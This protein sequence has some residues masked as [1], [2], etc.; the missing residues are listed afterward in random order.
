MV[1]GLTACVLCIAAAGWIARFRAAASGRAKFEFSDVAAAL[2]IVDRA[3]T[4]LPALGTLAERTRIAYLQGDD[5]VARLLARYPL[6]E[7]PS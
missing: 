3:A 7:P 2:G 5:G 1:A 6:T 4:R